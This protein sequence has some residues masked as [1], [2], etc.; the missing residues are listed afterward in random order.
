MKFGRK[1]TQKL[2]IPA[3]LALFGFTVAVN[4]FQPAPVQAT[5]AYASAP[6][7]GC[8]SCHVAGVGPSR[9]NVN[10]FGQKYA[11]CGYQL[12]CALA[13]QPPQVAQPNPYTPPPRN[14]APPGAPASFQAGKIWLVQL[15]ESNGNFA[16]I[17]WKFRPG[18][19]TVDAVMY[20]N[21][22][23]LE[24]VLTYEGYR[25]GTVSFY[26][27]KLRMRYTGNPTADTNHVFNGT[28]AGANFGR[29]DSWSA[30]IWEG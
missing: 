5:A 10:P 9:A 18:S 14:Y 24:D 8:T 27:P 4:Y 7:Y 23:H 29:G 21:G 20:V 19:N 26:S 15:R 3:A 17:I 13:P 11:Q 12:N 16:D 1:L 30:S 2:A 22:Q 6:S 25:N 28:V